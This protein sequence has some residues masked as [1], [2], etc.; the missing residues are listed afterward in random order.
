MKNHSLFHVDISFNSFSAEDIQ[1][2]SDGLRTNHQIFGFHTEGN[3]ST[4]DALGFVVPVVPISK[5]V[6]TMENNF[7]M[8]TMQGYKHIQIKSHESEM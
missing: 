6:K 3:N 2:I 1:T 7:N 4:V 8:L 5:N